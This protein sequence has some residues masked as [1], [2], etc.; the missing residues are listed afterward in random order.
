MKIDIEAFLKPRVLAE[1]D[2]D[3]SDSQK[4]RFETPFKNSRKCDTHDL[5]L[6]TNFF[7]NAFDEAKE[8]RKNRL[9]NLFKKNKS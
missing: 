1:N 4:Q 5:M 2:F 3:I 7:N 9:K 6:K 8:F